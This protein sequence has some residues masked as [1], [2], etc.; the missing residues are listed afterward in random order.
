M[1]M[2]LLAGFGVVLLHRPLHAHPAFSLWTESI[3]T[4]AEVQN[5]CYMEREEQQQYSNACSVL[6]QLL[7]SPCSCC[8]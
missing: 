2:I 4:P 3:N 7:T 5:L 6:T 8:Y 1:V